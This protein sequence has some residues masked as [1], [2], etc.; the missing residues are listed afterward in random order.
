MP[1]LLEMFKNKYG[2]YSI[3]KIVPVIWFVFL[4]YSLAFTFHGKDIPKAYYDL[5]IVFSSVYVGR[6]AVD[7][8]KDPTVVTTTPVTPTP[9]VTPTTT[10]IVLATTPAPAPTTT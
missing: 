8:I 10:P 3:S 6:A 7:K 4:L 5:T 9:T 1:A 2:K